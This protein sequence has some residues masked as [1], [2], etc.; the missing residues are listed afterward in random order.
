M[1]IIIFSILAPSTFPTALNFETMFSTGSV[2]LILCLGILPSLTA[3]EIDLSFAGIFGLA[4]II[5]A[6]TNVN[7]H[8]P[9]VVCLVI[10]VT[11]GGLVGVVNAVLTVWVGIPS[12]IITLGMGSLLSGLALGVTS[13]PIAGVSNALVAAASTRFLG[14]ELV[15]F[16]AVAATG[17]LWYVYRFTPLG[18]NLFFVGAG[19]EVAR[20]SGLPVRPLAGGTLIFGGLVAGL[21]GALLVGTQ[22][23]ADPTAGPTYLLPAF[24]G[25]FLGSTAITPGRFNPLGAFVAVFFLQTGTQ[26]LELLGLSG[27][28]DQAFYGASLIAAVVVARLGRRP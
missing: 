13:L 10:G 21:A 19:R 16:Y 4:A 7:L 15:F 8:I 17:V 1:L 2:L 14:F 22:G 3:G 24:A 12:L 9:I 11:A 23:S 5:V 26:G 20:L 18:R 27:W 6:Y 28:V 25:A